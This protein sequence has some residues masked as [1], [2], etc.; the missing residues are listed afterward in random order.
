MKYDDLKRI[1]HQI[2][3][4]NEALASFE[5]R[6]YSPPGISAIAG[7][8]LGDPQKVSKLEEIGESA[9]ALDLLIRASSITLLFLFFEKDI[10]TIIRNDLTML[11]KS[12]GWKIIKDHDDDHSITA[13]FNKWKKCDK[14]VDDFGWIL[15][16][17]RRDIIY[18][19]IDI[20]RHRP[21][22][23]VSEISSFLV[24]S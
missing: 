16:K 19:W 3:H 5:S 17:R 11:L 1:Q 23:I 22:S 4:E 9:V 12:S 13:T 15:R 10:N 7:L 6:L 2:Y 20:L 18:A 24:L 21:E 8:K 14:I